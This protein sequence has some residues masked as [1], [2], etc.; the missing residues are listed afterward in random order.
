[1]SAPDGV[2]R[3]DRAYVRYVAPVSL[4]WMLVQGAER[5]LGPPAVTSPPLPRTRN[6]SSRAVPKHARPSF[7]PVG[8]DGVG[9][10]D[11]VGVKDRVCVTDRVGVGISEE[12]VDGSTCLVCDGLVTSTVV[13]ADDVDRDGRGDGARL[14]EDAIWPLDAAPIG[15]G[16]LRVDVG[17]EP[18]V[19]AAA[20]PRLRMTGIRSTDA[21]S[22]TARA[23]TT[24]S[25]GARRRE[26][27]GGGS[28]RKGSGEGTAACSPAAA[29]AARNAGT[30]TGRSAGRDDDARVRILVMGA[31][32]SSR[33]IS[34]SVSAMA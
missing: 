33:N 1:M 2:S 27:R 19:T 18:I 9:V 5:K 25:M 20:L 34:A 6:P 7:A 26:G 14:D 21:R 4:R 16:T 8:R 28:S 31:G 12:V 24:G 11:R 29:S 15:V 32:T 10:T 22:S 3:H 23:A 13:A 17:P 30:S